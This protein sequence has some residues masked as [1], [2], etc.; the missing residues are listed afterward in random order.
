MSGDP[1]LPVLRCAAAVVV[2]S[3]APASAGADSACSEAPGAAPTPAACPLPSTAAASSCTVSTGP[4]SPWLGVPCGSSAPTR[5]AST[6]VD[7]LTWPPVASALGVEVG[8]DDG[9]PTTA[10]EGGTAEAVLHEPSAVA[11]QDGLADEAGAPG[12]VAGAGAEGDVAVGDED[13][14]P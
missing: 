5:S 14:G 10:T 2:S 4:V 7:P 1:E 3:D 13:G 12:D 11:V 9:G 6:S 8:D